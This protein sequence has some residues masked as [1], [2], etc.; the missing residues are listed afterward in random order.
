[1]NALLIGWKREYLVDLGGKYSAE[2]VFNF[3]QN[4]SL[5]HKHVRNAGI[6]ALAIKSNAFTSILRAM[7]I[8]QSHKH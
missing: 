8:L 1:M 7:K 3:V 6:N 2:K 5:G 4:I